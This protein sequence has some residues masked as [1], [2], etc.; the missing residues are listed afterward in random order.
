M[1][2][3][4]EEQS[5]GTFDLKVDGRIIEYDVEQGDFMAA[6]R[7]ARSRIPGGQK[8]YVEDLTGY[9]TSMTGG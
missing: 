9:R 2:V 7:R 4:F 8:I 3:V 5:G 6:L 1:A